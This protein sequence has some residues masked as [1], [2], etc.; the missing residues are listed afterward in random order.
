MA[1]VN[2]P[3][4]ISPRVILRWPQ[5]KDLVGKGRRQVQ[6][7]MAE[8]KFPQS[9]D[10]SEDGSG[11]ACGWY[12]DEIAAWQEGLSRRSYGHEQGMGADA[13]LCTSTA[14]GSAR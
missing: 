14:E 2:A 1:K 13:H 10:L 8:G 12:A 4:N 5:V 11:R 7:D 3:S 6:R 9:V